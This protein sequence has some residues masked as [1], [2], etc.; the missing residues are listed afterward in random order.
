MSGIRILLLGLLLASARQEPSLDTLVEQLSDDRVERREAAVE[1]LARL[2]PSRLDD[3]RKR[4]AGLDPEPKGRLAAA[5]LR[6]EDSVRVLEF[7][8]PYRPVSL[9]LVRMP[10]RDALK[11]L[12]SRTGLPI[13]LSTC[14]D[15]REVTVRVENVPPLQALTE[16]CKAAM[17]G[18]M[19]RS[20]SDW[21]GRSRFGLPAPIRIH[22]VVPYYYRP[23]AV[24]VVRH[25]RIEAYLST[26]NYTDGSV[27]KQVSLTIQPAAGVRPHSVSAVR[28][29]EATDEAGRDLLVDLESKGTGFSTMTLG[30]TSGGLSRTFPAQTMPLKLTRLKGSI[31]FRYPCGIR[32]V[33]F[34]DPADGLGKPQDALGCR[35]SLLKYR[36]EGRD[37][38]VVLS[39]TNIEGNPVKGREIWDELPFDYQEV[40]VVTPSGERL[41]SRSC[42]AWG[43]GFTWGLQLDMRGSKD[44]AAKE[45]RLPWADRFVEDVVEFDL[46][47]IVPQQ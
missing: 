45:I 24:Q 37:H 3:L 22:E 20:P 6:I 10:A 11:E 32:W 42:G 44:E 30:K 28:L 12:A 14:P 5:I 26:V 41:W 35:F 15:G 16:I 39:I 23:R 9:D 21:R 33:S 13:N 31:T 29:T 36:H 46:R 7:L 18:W 27:K 1:A 4:L 19:D 43:G 47:D 2:G 34:V 8:P 17:L 40:E 38:E 25:Y